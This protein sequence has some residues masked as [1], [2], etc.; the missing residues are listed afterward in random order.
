[1]RTARVPLCASR[2]GASIKMLCLTPAAMPCR[3][4]S[5]A[6]F[7]TLMPDT[8]TRAQRATIQRTPRRHTRASAATAPAPCALRYFS[9]L[10]VTSPLYYFSPPL[11]RYDA[12]G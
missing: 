8:E 3:A 12:A 1:M 9:R 6:D 7:F 2:H 4:R 11:L 5:F 10:L